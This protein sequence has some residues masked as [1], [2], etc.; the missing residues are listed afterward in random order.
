MKHMQK[1]T[2]QIMSNGASYRLYLN[3]I[4]TNQ[5]HN[6]HKKD[7]NNLPV[8]L[9]NINGGLNVSLNENVQFRKKYL[10]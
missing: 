7:Y 9:K 5:L 4:I 6:F 3:S 8:Y 1:K 10:N 2:L